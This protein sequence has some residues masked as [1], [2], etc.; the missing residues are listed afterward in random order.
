MN[1]LPEPVCI[2][3]CLFSLL[4]SIFLAS[5]DYAL[6]DTVVVFPVGASDGDRQC[7]NVTILQDDIVEGTEIF[8]LQASSVHEVLSL[9]V[10]D[11]SLSLTT[12]SIADSASE[13]L[14]ILL[15]SRN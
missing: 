4:C 8:F 13:C 15:S 3:Q 9:I 10:I 14:H 7:V 5:S 12:V 2:T 11:P 1:F 6:L